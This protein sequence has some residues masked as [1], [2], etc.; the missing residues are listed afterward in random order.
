MTA[1]I[2]LAVWMLLGVGLRLQGD[3]RHRAS[4]PPS[5]RRGRAL[6]GVRVVGG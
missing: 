5:M 6:A 1:L 4:G 2:A 3:G